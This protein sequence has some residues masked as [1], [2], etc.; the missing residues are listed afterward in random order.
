MIDIDVMDNLGIKITHY[1]SLS[2]CISILRKY[3]H[4]SMSD[5]KNS[6]ESNDFV[7]AC[8]YL[9]DEGLVELIKCY[10]ELS[11]AGCKIDIYDLGRIGSRE[12]LCNLHESHEI[13]HQQT[14]AAI[15][16]EIAAEDEEG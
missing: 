16:A 12:L 1:D 9:D 14:L 10:D 11:E 2:K 15:E 4:D 7:Y 6:I 8:D 13:T 5:I 3:R